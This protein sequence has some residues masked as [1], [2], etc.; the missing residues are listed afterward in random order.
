MGCSSSKVKKYNAEDEKS[1][2]AASVGLSESKEVKNND[3]KLN[4]NK[5]S[6]KSPNQAKAKRNTLSVQKSSSP[7]DLS[8]L[9]I[10]EQNSLRNLAKPAL[11]QKVNCEE[12]PPSEISQALK[13][14]AAALKVMRR[15]RRKKAKLEAEAKQQWMVI[16]IG[17]D[18]SLPQWRLF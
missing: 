16:L 7:D 1:N 10:A 8:L 13:D 11:D 6:E 12:L 3:S 5:V 2:C 14:E 18:F 15:A 4:S 9:M 17:F